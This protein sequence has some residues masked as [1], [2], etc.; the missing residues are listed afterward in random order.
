M[1]DI[2]KKKQPKCGGRRKT[3]KVKGKVKSRTKIKKVKSRT[4]RV[5]SRTKRKSKRVKSKP[6]GK[7]SCSTKVNDS[8]LTALCMSCF[9]KNGRKNGI[10]KM[11]MN[12]RKVITNKR[13]RK[14]IKGKCNTCNGN[15]F[16]FC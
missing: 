9:H 4:K 8:N 5:K 11:S 3:K 10:K 16:T 6:K 2:F 1:E 7:S 14:M 15:M 13:G 12:N